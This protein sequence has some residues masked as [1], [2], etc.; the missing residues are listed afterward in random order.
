MNLPK[1]YVYPQINPYGI[2]MVIYE[3]VQSGGTFALPERGT[4]AEVEQVG[5]CLFFILPAINKC[6]FLWFS[7]CPVLLVSWFKRTPKCSDEVLLSIFKCT[8]AVKCLLLLLCCFDAWNQI[9]GLECAKHLPHTATP[10]SLGLVFWRDY[11]CREARLWLGHIQAVGCELNKNVFLNTQT[12]KD[13]DRETCTQ[14]EWASH[15]VGQLMEM[16]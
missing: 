15:C 9:Q 6:P 5:L 13:R 11:T 4:P 16:L 14:K 12:Q 3:H 2:F 7:L 8:R 1:I 10:P